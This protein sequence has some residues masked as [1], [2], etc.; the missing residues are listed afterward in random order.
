MYRLCTRK[1]ACG[2]IAKANRVVCDI[3]G[4]SG[5]NKQDLAV[6]KLCCASHDRCDNCDSE[7]FHGVFE[8]NTIILQLR[9]FMLQQ[10]ENLLVRSTTILVLLKLIPQIVDLASCWTKSSTGN[11][12]WLKCILQISE[13]CSWSMTLQYVLCKCCRRT[14]HTTLYRN[15]IYS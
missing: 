10:T 5:V 6:D 4:C 7:W 14:P 1:G 9:N 3:T 12:R 11:L 8:I 2:K 15:I 13:C